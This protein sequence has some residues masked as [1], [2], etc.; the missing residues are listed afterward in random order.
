MAYIIGNRNQNELFPSAIKDYVGTEDPVRAYDAFVE[1]LD[2]QEMGFVINSYKAGAHEYHPGTLLKLIVY[3]Y[4]Y[5]ERS[6]R[7]L[8]LM[9][10][11]IGK[12]VLSQSI[13]YVV[14]IWH[15]AGLPDD[16]P[17]SQRE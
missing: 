7:R 4:S 14:S 15:K 3:G 1:N 8:V 6:S 11:G 10:M 5:G 17:I 9:K 12:G 13:L 2:L 16:I